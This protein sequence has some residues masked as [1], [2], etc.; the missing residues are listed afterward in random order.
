VSDRVTLTLRATL[1]ARLEAECVTGDRF[2]A[3]S[4]LEIS[5]LPV[6][7]GRQTARLGDVFH[8]TGGRSPVVVAEG[9]LSN[10]DGLGSRMTRGELLIVGG[11][12]HFVGVELAGGHVEV[13]GDAGDDAGV[14]MTGGALRVRGNAGHRL[15][16]THPGASRGMT[17]GEILVEGSV[18]SHTA[19][20]C[21]RG[22]VVVGGD[23]GAWPA[24]AMIA[25]TLVVFGRTGAE[26]GRG[27]K[28]G[29]LVVPGSVDIPETYRYASTFE[30]PFVRLL[31]IHLRRQ[32][33]L[34]IDDLMLQS[35][36]RRFTGDLGHPG[37]GE[38][39]ERVAG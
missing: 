16:G 38:I 2:E 12:G 14:A 24:H 29:S 19:E 8:V 23:T 25:G 33:G 31:M 6:W 18:G 4:E 17:G 30:P 1:S 11:A 34:A 5:A 9:E 37:R 28:R 13:R 22:L 20:R 21:R 3:L 15:G 26:P 39:L 36:Y 10:V 7:L 32:F 35:R 27:N